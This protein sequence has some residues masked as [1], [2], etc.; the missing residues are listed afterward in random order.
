[1]NFIVDDGSQNIRA[2]CFR[3]QTEQL[4]K[5]RQ[6]EIL[7]YKEL[8]E[9][10]EEVK[11]DLLGRMVKIS[12]RVTRNDMFDRLE[13]VAEHVSPDPDPEEELKRLDDGA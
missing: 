4:L 11:H 6:D 7:A 2:V 13:L 9:R 12:G 1:M 10:F 8:P 5:K 3:Q